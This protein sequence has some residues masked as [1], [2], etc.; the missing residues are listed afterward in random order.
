MVRACLTFLGATAK[1]LTNSI[2]SLQDVPFK[3]EDLVPIRPSNKIPRPSGLRLFH[4]AEKYGINVQR[5]MENWHKK[6]TETLF[7]R[8]RMK[9][10]APND[11]QMALRSMGPLS[12][13]HCGYPDPFGP[14]FREK[15]PHR[16]SIAF[17]DV[18]CSR[19]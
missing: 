1:S 9:Y 3:F 15:I 13:F 4:C 19:H 18:F 10:Y 6:C 12:L 7:E 2:Y 8:L 5:F 16:L 11:Y 17:E 14:H